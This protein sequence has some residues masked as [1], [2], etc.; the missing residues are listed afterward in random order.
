M[1]L[2]QNVNETLFLSSG[3]KVA[4]SRKVPAPIWSD[5]MREAAFSSARAIWQISSGVRHSWQPEGRRRIQPAQGG[6]PGGGLTATYCTPN[7]Q[8]C[9]ILPLNMFA[10][11]LA[12]SAQHIC[13]F[14]LW[15]VHDIHTHASCTV[16]KGYAHSKSDSGKHVGSF[17][18]ACLRGDSSS[19]GA[20][21]TNEVSNAW[22]RG[23]GAGWIGVADSGKRIGSF[24]FACLRG[25][26]CSPGARNTN[27]V[28]NAWARCSVGG[29][30]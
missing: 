10:D 24:S 15:V 1:N 22:A 11:L 19:P 5:G 14:R 3:L 2:E 12:S 6:S 27:E 4:K 13:T 23:G 21:N 8:V 9:C 28:S 17:S 30:G 29:S 18:F 26:R 7:A 16:N 20:R 25:D